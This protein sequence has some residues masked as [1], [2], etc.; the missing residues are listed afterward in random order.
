MTNLE[1]Q[2]ELL[3]VEFAAK[4]T[5]L[6]T[7]GLWDAL[8]E[9]SKKRRKS[10]VLKEAPKTEEPPS[11]A[12]KAVTNRRV[13]IRFLLN[14]YEGWWSRDGIKF[15]KALSHITDGSDPTVD[16]YIMRPHGDVNGDR[17][18]EVNFKTIVSRWKYYTEIK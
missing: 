11:P 9:E 15:Y 3:K 8:E 16:K 12:R 17:V 5:L 7:N 4:L 14:R 13:H 10:S 6:I 1:T 18:L 2:L